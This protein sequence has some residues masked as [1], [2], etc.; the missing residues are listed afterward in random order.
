MHVCV[1]IDICTDEWMM[2]DRFT[3]DYLLACLRVCFSDYLLCCV[4]VCVY[5]YVYVFVYTYVSV[6]VSVFIRMY[7]YA[8]AYAYAHVYICIS[9]PGKFDRRKNDDRGCRPCETV[10]NANV[11]HDL[12]QLF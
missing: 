9:L 2:D 8:Y 7:A 10:F 3:V 4:C 12:K 5:V 1:Y 11:D 6:F